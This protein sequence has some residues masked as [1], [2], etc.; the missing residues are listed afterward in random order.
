MPSKADWAFD[1]RPAG[2]SDPDS[3]NLERAAA[4]SHGLA[5]WRR[6]PVAHKVKQ[7]GREPRQEQRIGAAVLSC[8]G[9]HFEH[10][11]SSMTHYRP[12][13]IQP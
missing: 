13:A 12:P 2:V 5:L 7:F 3:G 11:A 6:E 4:V 9:G 10:A 8:V 1:C